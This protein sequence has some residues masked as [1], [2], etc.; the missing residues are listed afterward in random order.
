MELSVLS[1]KIIIFCS[2]VLIS[3]FPLTASIANEDLA[4]PSNSNPFG[5]SY[6][7]W[8]VEWWKWWFSITKGTP[9]TEIGSSQG[10]CFLGTEYNV[11]FLIDAVAS[12]NSPLNFNC[13]I[14]HDKA[15]LI[16]AISELCSY[17][18]VLVTDKQLIECVQQR[19][20]Y[21]MVTVTVDGT[22]LE[23]TKPYKS[24]PYSLRTE[25]FNFTYPENNVFD[26]SPGTFRSIS[27]GMFIILKPLSVGDHIIKVKVVQI[28]PGREAEN[29]Y[30]DLTYNMHVK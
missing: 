15:I 9:Y 3:V 24:S 2:L 14:P 16:N 8:S 18:D 25:F 1:Q 7:D 11:L 26:N 29:L 17:G 30:L 19:N 13:T 28:I 4:F 5:K 6:A 12:V 27:D 23:N 21:A 20:P 10:S 22:E